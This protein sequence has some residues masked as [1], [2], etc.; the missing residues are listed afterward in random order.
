MW[1]KWLVTNNC[2]VPVG[3]CQLDDWWWVRKL[4]SLPLNQWGLTDIQ[5]YH[6]YLTFLMDDIRH[7]SIQDCGHCWYCRSFCYS[8]MHYFPCLCR[9]TEHPP[10]YCW[11]DIQYVSG[12]TSII[13]NG[14]AVPIKRGVKQWDPLSSHLFSIAI[15][16][17]VYSIEAFSGWQVYRDCKLELLVPACNIALLHLAVEAQRVVNTNA[18]VRHYGMW[19]WGLRSKCTVLEELSKKK[20]WDVRG[21]HI[22]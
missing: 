18:L 14:T 9:R 16:Q 15:D 1:S 3:S 6:V 8:G 4:A 13:P 11:R 10:A 12:V 22:P 2:Q 7:K 19:L 21:C 20:A 5:G 17:V